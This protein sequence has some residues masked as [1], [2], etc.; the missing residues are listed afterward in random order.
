M[1]GSGKDKKKKGTFF[2]GSV[3]VINTFQKFLVYLSVSRVYKRK[4]FTTNKFTSIGPKDT[5]QRSL[6]IGKFTIILTF[7][8]LV[9]KRYS[10]LSKKTKIN[11]QEERKGGG[12]RE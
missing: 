4:R 9:L 1:N 7:E 8:V 12:G 2:L 11:Y 3:V 6:W 10:L 5:S